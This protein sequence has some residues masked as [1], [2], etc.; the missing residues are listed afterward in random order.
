MENLPLTRYVQTSDLFVE[1]LLAQMLNVYGFLS[2]FPIDNGR[3]GKF[4]A[5]AKFFHDSC[6]FEFSLEFFQGFF[7]VFTFFDRNYDHC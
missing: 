6:F 3:F 4:L 5:F 2:A 1:L 7:D